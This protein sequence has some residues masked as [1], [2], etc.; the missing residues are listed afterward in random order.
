MKGPQSRRLAKWVNTKCVTLVADLHCEWGFGG[1]A[2]A[3]YDRG[4]EVPGGLGRTA[5]L[6]RG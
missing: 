4:L 1:A 5:R 2:I 3:A 6:G